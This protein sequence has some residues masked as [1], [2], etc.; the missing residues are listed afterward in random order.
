MLQSTESIDVLDLGAGSKRINSNR[1]KIS[2]I[3][4][5]SAVDRKNGELLF[6]L[7]NYFQPKTIVELGTSL[8]IGT[9]Y[10]AAADSRNTVYSIEGCPET[11]KKAKENFNSFGT[12]NIISRIGGFDEILHVI[13]Q[14]INKVD[15]VY[16]DGNHR[17]EPTLKYFELCLEKAHSETIFVFDDIHWSPE[18]ESAWKIIQ[19]HEKVTLSLDLF[20]KGIIFFKPELSK[21]HFII[22][23]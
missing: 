12:K 22:R 18:M 7:V 21:Q 16:F 6:K 1:R 10:L 23:F 13:L 4:R 20:Q 9:L 14:E 3:A 2:D 17:K 11:A 19:N 15:F 5:F 8:G